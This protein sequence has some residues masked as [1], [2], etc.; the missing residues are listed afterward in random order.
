MIVYPVAK[1]NIGL[2]ITE[3]REDGFHN[4]ETIFYPVKGIEDA[5]EVVRADTFNFSMTGLPVDGIPDDN[6]VVKAYHMWQEKFGLPPV[7][8][9]LHKAIPTG[10]GL[11]GGSSDGAAMLQLLNEFFNLEMTSDKM[12]K[13]ALSLGSD[14]PFF[15]QERPVFATGRGEIMD[16]VEL[17]LSDFHLIIVKPDSRISTAEAYAHVHP[18]QTR[19]SLKALID[20]PIGRWRGN[21][22]NQFEK[23]VFSLCPEV[24]QLKR[25]LYDNGASFALMSGSGSAVYGLFHSEKRGLEELFP[26]TWQVFRQKLG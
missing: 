24:E 25:I 6:L 13:D 9:H 26:A 11:G 1:I 4:L 16:P 12:M 23:Y 21:I 15:I 14:C 10:A 17:N 5:L 18:Q 22:Q 7:H 2:R 20:F 3:K 19:I 8:I